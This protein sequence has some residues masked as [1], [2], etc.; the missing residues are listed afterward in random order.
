[1]SSL[2]PRIRNKPVRFNPNPNPNPNRNPHPHPNKPKKRKDSS[3][4]SI[5]SSSSS[6]NE[7]KKTFIKELAESWQLEGE[8]IKKY[9]IENDYTFSGARGIM[10]DFTELLKKESI[11]SGANEDRGIYCG[12]K[13]NCKKNLEND[14]RDEKNI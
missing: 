11:K 5:I 14:I 12:I 7:E 3:S 6:D 8:Y 1:M 10:K 4:S 13:T 9:L 2:P